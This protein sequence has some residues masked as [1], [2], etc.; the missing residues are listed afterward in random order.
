M[1]DDLR[2]GILGASH[3]ALTR[4]GP[5]LH[6]AR[7]SRVAALATSHPEKAA[8]FAARFGALRVHHDYDALLADPEI[9]AVYIP[10][11]NHLHVA[12]TRR[13][14]EAGKHVLCEKPVA[15]S[16]PE[17]DD[18][19][20]ARDHSRLVAAE[21]FMIVH[22]PQW[23]RA[24]ALLQDGAVGELIAVNAAF[25]YNNPDPANI[26][27]RVDAGGGGLADIGVYTHGAVRFAT[28]AEPET[29]LAVDIARENGVDVR[30]HATVRFPSFLYTGYVATRMAP[31]QEMV[32]HGSDGV[33]RLT[34]PF[35]AQ[36]YGQAEIR[37][38]EAGNRVVVE[39]FPADNH[40]VLQVEAFVAAALDGAAYPCPLEFSRGTQAMTDM[41]LAAEAAG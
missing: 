30:A 37:L 20:A 41:L 2:W 4:M 16:A 5:A 7:R 39:R 23:Q 8:P 36:V 29:V 19:I 18:L 15:M 10:L 1:S 24:R 9:D 13:A 38:H 26:R 3:F 14:L 22:H 32:F 35:N 33:L 28:G 34:A 12:Y 6:A 25:S 17:I 11:P 31:Y 40:Y 21:A 27:N